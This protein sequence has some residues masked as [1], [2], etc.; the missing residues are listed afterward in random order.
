MSLSRLLTVAEISAGTHL[1]V[2]SSLP[3]RSDSI[4][5]RAAFAAARVFDPQKEYQEAIDLRLRT[6]RPILA[7]DE[8]A[9]MNPLI[10]TITRI[11]YAI[12][13]LVNRKEIQELTEASKTFPHKPLA[14]ESSSEDDS[15]VA[16]FSD[17]GTDYSSDPDPVFYDANP[18]PA[19][20]VED[21]ND[22]IDDDVAPS[23]PLSSGN[24]SPPGSV[25]N[26]DGFAL[27]ER[28]DPSQIESL[29]EEPT[30]AT[31]T[32]LGKE[33]QTMMTNIF[34]AM[35]YRCGELFA[36][37]VLPE[38]TRIDVVLS[39]EGQLFTATFASQT[40]SV[41]KHG[42]AYGSIALS[43]K[44]LQGRVDYINRTITFVNGFP[45]TVN[46]KL[47]WPFRSIELDIKLNEITDTQGAMNF[48]IS[49]N[50]SL[51]PRAFSYLLN[52]TLGTP[53]LTQQHLEEQ[54]KEKTIQW[55]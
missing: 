39:S 17:D 15:N 23:P 26:D 45:M 27:V 44:V 16:F 46:K 52:K 6:V 53:I 25:S 22:V 35:F 54:L 31:L 37:K 20:S 9:Q 2:G 18:P 40:A 24:S 41:S 36:N 42:E 10:R 51:A 7:K 34:A 12:V 43:S 50:S 33:A 32:Y 30:P 47:P 4:D 11:Y 21:E 29:Q 13:C 8:A 1:K 3:D 19:P 28:D 14:T 49:S 55:A 38:V 48:N 5:L